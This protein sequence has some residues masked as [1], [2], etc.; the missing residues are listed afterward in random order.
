MRNRVLRV[1]LVLFL[2][3]FVAVYPNE[4]AQIT[5]SVAETIVDVASTVAQSLSDFI[6]GLV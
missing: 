3:Y 6:R 2:L 1:S 5:R 4:A